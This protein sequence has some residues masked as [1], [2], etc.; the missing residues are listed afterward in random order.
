MSTNGQQEAFAPCNHWGILA[1]GGFILMCVSN[2]H[3]SS[4]ANHL[5]PLNIASWSA[6]DH[7]HSQWQTKAI[8]MTI[9]SFKGVGKNKPI[10]ED[11][12]PKLSGQVY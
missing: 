9:P 7:F 4:M 6:L 1:D 8:H 12:K 5:L 10:P 2:D 11:Q 3:Q